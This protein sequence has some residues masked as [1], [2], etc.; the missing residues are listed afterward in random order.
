MKEI[1]WSKAPDGATHANG[2]GVFLRE[3]PSGLVSEF[4]S[5]AWSLTRSKLCDFNPSYLHQRPRQAWTGEGLPPVG[6]VCEALWNTARDEWFQVKIFGANEHGQPVFRW[7][8]GPEKY[9]YQAGTLTGPMG[10]KHFRPLRTPEQ[11]AAE[12]R[13]KAIE[14]MA[15][16]GS[17]ADTPKSIAAK[18]YDAG[19]RLVTP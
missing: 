11:I 2:A 1:D 8:D 4:E 12:E 10:H 17:M 9:Q 15:R 13:E 5:G 19:C 14:E 6:T 16:I 7:E 18:L 3:N